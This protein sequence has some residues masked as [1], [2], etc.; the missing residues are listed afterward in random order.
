MT[1]KDSADRAGTYAKDK[2]SAAAAAAGDAYSTAKTAAG[3]AYSTAKDRAADALGSARDTAAEARRRTADGIDESPI[4]ALIGGL[5]LGAIAAAF[6][7]RT[8]KE[9]ELLG[10][11]GGKINDTARNAAQAA[12]EAGRDKLE[13]LGINKDAAI[14]KAKELAQTAAGV[15]R[16]SASAAA[17]SVK[18]GRNPADVY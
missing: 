2:A 6:L 7:P 4:A 3:D 8:Q 13:E 9:D 12:K 17:S 1:I 16:E 18:S 15:A 11:L 10:N 14:D 5:A